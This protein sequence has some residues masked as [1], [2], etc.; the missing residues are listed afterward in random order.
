MATETAYAPPQTTSTLDLPELTGGRYELNLCEF[1]VIVPFAPP[2]DLKS[3]VIKAPPRWDMDSQQEIISS[4][5][6][7]PSLTNG[8][9]N[10][11]DA[12]VLRALQSIAYDYNEF[13]KR[14]V[15]F[16]RYELAKKLQID[17]CGKTW[18]RLFKSLERLSEVRYR[19]NHAWWDH[20]NK[21]RK[22]YDRFGILDRVY[23]VE[24]KRGRY[25]KNE[26]AE[27][28]FVWGD[29]IFESLNSGYVR[30]IDNNV[31]NRF[32]THVAHQTYFLLKKRFYREG[33]VTIPLKK[34]CCY[35]LGMSEKYT[36]A[37][38]KRKLR[39]G[40]EQ[41]ETE[42]LIK[43][44][45]YKDRYAKDK[46]RGEWTV[47]FHHQEKRLEK[48]KVTSKVQSELFGD[49]LLTMDLVTRGMTKVT[50]ARMVQ[51]YDATVIE[52]QMEILNW[53]IQRGDEIKE[54]GAWLRKAIQNDYAKPKNFQ[55]QDERVAE[56]A[57]ISEA[58]KQRRREDLETKE[59]AVEKEKQAEEKSASEWQEINEY[60]DALPLLDR[61]TCVEEAI[62]TLPT[63]MRK[64]ARKYLDD[65]KKNVY[66]EIA[67]R[68]HV[69]PFVVP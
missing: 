12:R 37:Q 17:I 21:K 33:R 45:P 43:P 6:I 28:F 59:R 14:K 15:S 48:I 2:A 13:Q 46:H 53:K 61:Q 1:P 40:I 36:T 20:K 64:N 23:W 16:T 22:S 51:E 65:G 56:S 32:T 35:H 24:G 63:T 7:I 66:Y 34:Y 25:K 42:G 38:M 4:I 62:L 58:K 3:Y 44:L 47:V 67:L 11:F 5:E 29:K 69:L 55:T 57:A 54:P 60:L 50:A 18:K 8:F 52:L 68:N 30:E 27:C 10:A 9:P 39:K 41:L 26:E 19:V 49:D 31:A